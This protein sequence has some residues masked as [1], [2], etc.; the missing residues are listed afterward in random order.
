M[1]GLFQIPAKNMPDADADGAP[2]EERP[3][4]NGRQQSR[5]QQQPKD[6]PAPTGTSAPAAQPNA[7][8]IPGRGGY[9]R[10]KHNVDAVGSG[11]SGVVVEPAG[12]PIAETL[13]AGIPHTDKQVGREGLRSITAKAVARRRQ[14]ETGQPLEYEKDGNTV[15]LRPDECTQEA[16]QVAYETW[17]AWHR[18]MHPKMAEAERAKVAKALAAFGKVAKSLNAAIAKQAKKLAAEAAADGA[19]PST[20]EVLQ[21]ERAGAA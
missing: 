7:P 6:R 3:A 16:L 2:G 11:P 12:D 8:D 21:Y 1:T 10:Q 18:V 5:P 9:G 17:E 15:R 19:D 13:L 14:V 20:G 4:P